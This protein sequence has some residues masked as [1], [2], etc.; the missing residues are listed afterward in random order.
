MSEKEN[1]ELIRSRAELAVALK[2]FCE[3]FTNE[4]PCLNNRHCDECQIRRKID[5]LKNAVNWSM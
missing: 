3:T 1:N 2:K 5:Y 4:E